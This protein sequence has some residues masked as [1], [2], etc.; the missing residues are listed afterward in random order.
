MVA[1]A[2]RKPVRLA[3]HGFFHTTSDRGFAGMLLARLGVPSDL[4][5]LG[6]P[7]DLSGLGVLVVPG[8]LSVLVVPG[9]LSGLRVPSDL[10]GLGVRGALSVLGTLA[11]WRTR[12]SRRTRR[13]WESACGLP[14][15]SYRSAAG[16]GIISLRGF[17]GGFFLALPCAQVNLR[18]LALLADIYTSYKARQQ[19]LLGLVGRVK[20]KGGAGMVCYGQVF[21]DCF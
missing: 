16:G 4:G 20:C 13:L 11:T 7:G 19:L 14:V 6:V 15:R 17:S 5:G 3:L 18:K 21:A 12:C 9:D 2:F 1:Q 10:S 8:D